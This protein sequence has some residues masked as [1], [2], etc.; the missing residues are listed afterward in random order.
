MI[1]PAP[2]LSS[3]TIVRALL[4]LS[5]VALGLI[6]LLPLPANAFENKAFGSEVVEDGEVE[7]EVS[8]MVGDV[9]VDGTVEGDVNSGFGDI[10]VRGEEVDDINAGH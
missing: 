2:A 8:T 1:L 4:T 3:Q 10:E 5:V 7:D 6:V 9:R